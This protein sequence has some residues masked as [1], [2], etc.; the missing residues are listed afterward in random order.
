MLESGETVL[1]VGVMLLFLV[2][3]LKSPEARTGMPQ[4]KETRRPVEVLPRKTAMRL[5][6]TEPDRKACA[7]LSLQKGT[8]E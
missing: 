1:V 3:W 8:G 5:S 7:G 2:F 4:F 6:R